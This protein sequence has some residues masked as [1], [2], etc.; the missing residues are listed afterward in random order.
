MSN[1]WPG[2]LIRKTPVTPA[3]PVRNGAAPGVWTLADAAYWTKQGLWPNAANAAGF[4]ATLGGSGT[5]AGLGIALDSS[6]NI[7]ATGQTNSTGAGSVDL[8]ITK[9]SN[10][11]VIQWQRTLGGTNAEYGRGIAV[12]TSG[13][14]YVVGY[15][16]TT[17]N[18]IFLAKYDTNGGIQWQLNLA[19]S[20]RNQQGN[21]IAVDTSGNVYLVATASI[22]GEG[23][24]FLIAKYNSS[25]T[26]QWQRRLGG[27][28][29]ENGNGIAVDASAN[30]YVTGPTNSAGAGSY[31]FFIAKYNTS[32]TIQWQRTL[33]DYSLDLAY[34]IAVDPSGNTYVTGSTNISGSTAVLTAKYDTSGTLQWQKTLTGFSVEAGYGIAV[35]SSGDCYLV[36]STSST[37]AGLEDI[38]IAKYDTNGSLYW[39]R[40][41]GGASND[42]GQGI[43]VDTSGNFYIVGNTQSAGAGGA[44]ILIAKLPGDGSLTGTYGSFT[45]GVGGLT[46]ATPTF[47]SS[48]VSLTSATSSLTSSTTSYTDASSSL[49]STVIDV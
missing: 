14:A 1:R 12:D 3:G 49:T 46:P 17:G 30:V 48:T 15:N 5:D 4:I 35:N 25:G 26:L 16:L 22:V 47:T 45:Y 31:D 7:Y 18:N 9:Y 41:L 44:D 40:Y 21:G 29:T 39:Q 8:I 34:G 2:G 33:G 20:G 36:G 10:K 27:A 38:L 42:R 6:G 28:S 19:T 37:G 24:N 13:N 23:D 11:G 43:V 32:G